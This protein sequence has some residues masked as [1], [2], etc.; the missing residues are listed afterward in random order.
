VNIIITATMLACIT[1][2]FNLAIQ[3][4][5]HLKSHLTIRIQYH[6]HNTISHTQYNITYT[7][8]YH[9]H[10]VSYH[11]ALHLEMPLHLS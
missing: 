6:I 11:N 1:T 7:I 2:V 3:Y 4:L 8:Q 5:N 10:N 9:I